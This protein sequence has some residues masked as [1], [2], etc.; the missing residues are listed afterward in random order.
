MLLKSLR[1]TFLAALSVH[2][3]GGLWFFLSCHNTVDMH[4]PAASLLTHDDDHDDHHEACRQDTWGNHEGISNNYL[5]FCSLI[6]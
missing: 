1:F 4:T 5:K 6:D 3:T 2:I